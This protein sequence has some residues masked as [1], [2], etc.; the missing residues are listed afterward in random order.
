MKKIRCLTVLYLLLCPFVFLNAQ[1]PVWDFHKKDSI[2]AARCYKYAADTTKY[3]IQS[4]DKKVKDD[5][6]EIYSHRLEQIKEVLSTTRAVTDPAVVKY[7]QTVV[8]KITGSNEELKNLNPRIVFS[9]DWWPNAYSMGE[10]TIIVNAGLF[11]YLKTEAEL[12]FVLAHEIAHLYLNHSGRSVDRY[13]QTINSET[14]KSELKR[15]SKEE[16]MVNRQLEQLAKTI[17]FNNRKHS[18][19]YETDA[20]RKAYEYLLKS[21]FY[22]GAVEAVLLTL[23]K[24]DDTAYFNP[25]QADKLLNFTNYPFK[26]KWIQKESAI[27]SEMKEEP[28]KKK[29]QEEDSLKTH[30]DCR[31]RI[32]LLHKNKIIISGNNFLV[33]ESYFQKLQIDFL[34]EITEACY[35]NNNLSRNLYYSLQMIQENRFVPYAVFSTARSLNKMYEEQKNHRLGLQVDTENNAFPDDYNLLLRLLSRIRLH[36][37]GLLILHFC[38]THTDMMK[39]YTDFQKEYTIAQQRTL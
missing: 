26:Q 16:Y 38:A 25:L 5:Y 24:V 22:T 17:V 39:S 21:G 33:N 32:E 13:V 27:F 34:V 6:K 36:E 14:F 10:G 11:V 7:L 31:K 1:T 8:E 19:E 28:N 15:L 2:F 3:I 37:L 12:A 18:R 35:E 20:D 29:E 4:S 30:P 23:D 9:K